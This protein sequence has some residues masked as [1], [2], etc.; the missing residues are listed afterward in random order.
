[1]TQT[2]PKKSAGKKII[3]TLPFSVGHCDIA[4]KEKHSH[5][6]IC[7]PEPRAKDLGFFCNVAKQV[8]MLHF[9]QHDSSIP[10]PRE[11]RGRK[12]AFSPPL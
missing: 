1:L 3:H 7:H 2:Y 12:M 6:F 11:I 9:V 5:P 8:E 4:N 10:L